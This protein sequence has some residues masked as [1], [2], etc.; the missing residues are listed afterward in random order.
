MKLFKTKPQPI[1]PTRTESLACVPQKNP[2]VTWQTLD[3]GALRLE[4]PLNIRAFFIKLAVRRQKNPM[5]SP[6]KKVQLD[7]LGG[8]VWGLVDGRNSVA[9][10]IQEFSTNS[11]LSLAEAEISVTAFL[12]DLGRRGLI[13]L[14]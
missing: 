5:E 6:T 13:F 12:R 3:D 11:G 7:K 4:Y 14:S 1:Q 10:I 9:G 2:A 8:I